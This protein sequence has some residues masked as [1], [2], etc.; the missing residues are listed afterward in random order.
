MNIQDKQTIKVKNW[1][2]T[3]LNIITR[4]KDIVHINTIYRYGKEQNK[5]MTY[6][7]FKKWQ[8]DIKN[9]DSYK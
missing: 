4:E 1:N 2:D 9:T 8:D 3:A 5:K 7:D 6:N